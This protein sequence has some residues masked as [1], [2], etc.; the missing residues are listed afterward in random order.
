MKL[1]LVVAS[2]VHEGKAI[3]ITTFTS[4]GF[5][6]TWTAELAGKGIRANMVSPGPIETPLLEGQ[7]G[8][9]IGHARIVRSS[10]G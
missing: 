1:R 3:P 6:R 7:F 4:F 9:N 8:P 10:P 2:G 5:I